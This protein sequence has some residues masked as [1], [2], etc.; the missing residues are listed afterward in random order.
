MS[1]LIYLRLEGDIQGNISA[2]CG[3][4]NSIGNR[5]QMG[6]ED[7]IQVFGL[8]QAVS[9]HP[10]GTHHHGLRF[11]KTLDKSSP[12][13]NNAINNNERL[14]M[15]FDIYRINQYGRLENYYTIELRAARIQSLDCKITL[16]DLPY[17]YVSVEYD[18]ICCRHL[19]AGTEFYDLLIP[20]QSPQLLPIVQKIPL[21]PQPPE[22]KVTLVMGIF[23]DGTGNN[24]VNTGS[25]LKALTAQHFDIEDPDAESILAKNVSEK[26]GI[27]GVGASSY[28][29]YYTNIHWLNELYEQKFPPDSNYIQGVLYVEGIGT[30]AGEP[31]DPIGLGLGS[32]ATG[33]IAKTDDAVA[34]LAMAIKIVIARLTGKFVVENLMFD[35]F[36]FSRGA[37]AARH[38]ANRVQA[39]DNTII[40]AIS[41][42][43]SKFSYSGTPAGKTRFLGI[44]DTVAAVGTVANGLDPHSA[45]TGDVNILLRPGVAQKVF[46]ITAQHECRYNFALNS[47]A[48]AWPELAL[49]GVHSDIG[50]GYL[51]QLR[52][53]LFLTR[54]QVE[55]RPANQPG[56][57][58]RVYRQAKEQLRELAHCPTLMPLIHT[59]AITPEIWEDDYAPADRYSQPQKRTFAALTLRHR[60]VRHAW[61]KVVLRVMVDA[62]KEGGAVFAEIEKDLKYALPDELKPY[63][64]RARAMGKLVR[65]HKSVLGF[66]P[67]EVDIIARNFIHCSAHWNAVTLR[68]TGELQGGTAASETIGFVNR[69]DENWT[70]TVYNMDGIKR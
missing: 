2:G 3:S 62:A 68:Q 38:F 5:Y 60:V 11:C 69:P 53:D 67:D 31:D 66:T 26:M 58:S 48:P 36:G 56:A 30:R 43:L 41:T 32:A 50:G 23:F 28:L 44:M 17:E 47:V 6:H 65:Q 1:Q 55:T 25:M 42:G 20:D 12:L 24:A 19:I 27:R 8:M 22:R 39:G 10:G 40:H 13:L 70:R 57:N 33:I 49:P 52:E 18:Y 9:R 15:L 46:H 16:K 35:I 61:S 64:E 45:D 63:C 59:N 54:P 21:P 29:G 34:Q 7:E 37:A 4:Q 14:N 51:P